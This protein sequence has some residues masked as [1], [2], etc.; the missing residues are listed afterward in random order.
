MV[1]RSDKSEESSSVFEP[2]YSDLITW[3]LYRALLNEKRNGLRNSIDSLFLNSQ[4]IRQ[5]KRQNLAHLLDLGRFKRLALV[6]CD[7]IMPFPW[8]NFSENLS[9]LEIINPLPSYPIKTGLYLS[10]NLFQFPLTFFGNL[11]V[12]VLENVGAPI[13]DVLFNLCESGNSLKILKLHDQ[14]CEGLDRTYDFHHPLN[15][16][17]SNHLQCPM[18]KLL[19]KICPHVQEL[20]VDISKNYWMLGLDTKLQ[21]A[22]DSRSIPLEPL[23]EEMACD[24]TWAISDILRSFSMLRSLHFVCRLDLDENLGRDILCYAQKVWSPVLESFSVA[25]S[26]DIKTISRANVGVNGDLKAGFKRG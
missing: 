15:R 19:R 21:R 5:W 3:D 9:A 4:N 20:S 14:E 17:Q 22:F 25:T 8:H 7:Q 10:D 24:P 1:C 12:L 26:T 23:F 2:F 16:G 11:E 13:C 18:V 6:D